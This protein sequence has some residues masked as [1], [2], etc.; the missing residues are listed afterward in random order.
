MRAESGGEMC[1]RREA[2]NSNAVGINFPLGSVLANEA[3]RALRI[4]KCSGGFGIRAGVG[5]AILHQ[6][7]VTSIELSQSQTSVPSRSMA[8]IG[9]AAPGNTTTAGRAALPFAA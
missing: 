9:I 4:L 2:E 8:R 6:P 5:H 7:Q 3:E 1:A